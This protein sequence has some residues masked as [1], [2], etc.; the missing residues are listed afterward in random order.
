M[1]RQTKRPRQRPTLPALPAQVW[2]LASAL[3]RDGSP[4]LLC[5]APG[6]VLGVCVPH[7]PA[8]WGFP[9]GWRAAC[10]YLLCHQCGRLP[11]RAERAAQMLW[12]ERQ[13]QL[14]GP[15]N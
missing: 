8:A 9:A 1:A 13:R 5:Q 4:C 14:A 12:T 11:D 7:S 15:W 6:G 2:R 10:P 3:L